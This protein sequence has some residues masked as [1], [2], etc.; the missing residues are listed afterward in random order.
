MLDFVPEYMRKVID[1]HDKMSERFLQLE[2][3]G[4]TKEFFSCSEE[5]EAFYL[6]RAH[7]VIARTDHEREWFSS[8]VPS[9][10]VLTVAHFDEPRFLEFESFP[11]ERPI[12]FGILA[13]ENEVNKTIVENFLRVLLEVSS[14]SGRATPI[15]VEIAGSVNKLV[16]KELLK[17]VAAEAA[18]EITFSGF[19]FDLDEFYSR[20]DCLLSPVNVGTGIN[21]KSVEAIQRGVPLISTRLGSKGISTKEPLH[22][23][24]NVELLVAKIQTMKSSELEA[25]ALTSREI[26]IGFYEQHF[27][28]LSKVIQGRL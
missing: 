10:E 1:T 19:I 20:I 28:T 26:A 24:D 14:G 16:S 8:L 22:G 21:V 2:Q 25:L 17:Q 5:D 6:S 27:D 13:S 7:T 3:A 9:K 12:R 23:L 18:L 11:N 4:V 15:F